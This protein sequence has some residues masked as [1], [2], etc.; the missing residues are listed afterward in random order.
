MFN[1]T[2]LRKYFL[3]FLCLTLNSDK[4]TIPAIR[5]CLVKLLFF[6][7]LVLNTNIIYGF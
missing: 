5:N 4:F 2:A 6:V 1:T 7:K 3:R